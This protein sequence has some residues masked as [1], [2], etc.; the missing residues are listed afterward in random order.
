MADSNDSGDKTEKP[1]PKKLQDARRKGQV[2][3]S[4]DLTGTLQLVGFTAVLLLGMAW[5]R[6]R[7]RS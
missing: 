3:K 6:R 7:W 5:P 2:P 1:T 4:R